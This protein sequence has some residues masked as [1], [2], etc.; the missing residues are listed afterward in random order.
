MT[1]KLEARRSHSFVAPPSFYLIASHQLMEVQPKI[2]GFK[3]TN[4]S[5]PSRCCCLIGFQCR[6]SRKG[7]S[8]PTINLSRNPCVIKA[9]G[10][11]LPLSPPFLLNIAPLPAPALWPSGKTLAQRS[12]GAWFDPRPS[13]TKDFKIGNSS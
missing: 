3:W 2:R 7:R 10:L 12:G 5:T 8:L 9:E 4:Q 1:T 13:Q 11:F 6:R